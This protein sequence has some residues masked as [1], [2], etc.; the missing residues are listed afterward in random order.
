MPEHGTGTRN[1]NKEH[2]LGH[3]LKGTGTGTRNKN[4]G[5]E[6]E[7]GTKKM[8]NDVPADV[9]AVGTAYGAPYSVL[10]SCSSLPS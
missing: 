3:V 8:K 1:R 5:W 10:C 9:P 7:Q 2:L 4:S 6:Q